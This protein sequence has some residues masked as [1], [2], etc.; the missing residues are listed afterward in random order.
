MAAINV[1]IEIRGELPDATRQELD[2]FT[3]LPRTD[4][5]ML[6][7]VVPDQAA[8]LGVLHRLHLAGVVVEDVEQVD[9]WP[10]DSSG[11]EM[12]RIQVDGR[13]ADYLAAQLATAH[14]SEPET[15]TIEVR[16]AGQEGLF[17]LLSR[18]Q[19]LAV[20]LR[21]AHIRPERPS[22]W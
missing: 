3:E 4:G 20:N 6:W 13:V 2:G 14:L 7:G 11:T 21:E 9:E 15:T 10:D 8:L 17:A 1:R 22:A 19:A 16:V 18:L 12:A 5:W